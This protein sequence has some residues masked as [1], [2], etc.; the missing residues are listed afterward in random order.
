MMNINIREA[1][2]G[3]ILSWVEEDVEVDSK[4]DY[5]NREM[6]F[7]GADD[8]DAL[9]EYGCALLWELVE[10]LGLRGGRYDRKRVRVMIEVGDKYEPKESE[11]LVEEIVEYLKE[12]Q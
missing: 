4:G 8:P 10:L 3:Y 2:N 12:E 1:E 9:V 5:T 7:G 6:V 11:V